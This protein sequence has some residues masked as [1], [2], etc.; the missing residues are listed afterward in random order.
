MTVLVEDL[1]WWSV[2][3]QSTVGAVRR[4]ATALGTELGLSDGRVADLGIVAAE[5]TSNLLKHANDGAVHLRALR[6][7]AGRPAG[8]ELVAIDAGPGMA[9]LVASS[10]DGHS[11]AGTLGIGLGAISRQATRLDVFSEPGR[12]TV[13]V[14]AVWGGRPPPEPWA[15]GLTRPIAGE[16]VSGDAYSVREVSGRRQ[17]FLS[18]G[19]GHGPLASRASQTAA[20]AFRDA[21]AGSPAAVLEHLHRA[22]AHTRGAVGAVIELDR[23]AGVLSCASVGNIAGWVVG[24]QRRR[25]L[26]AQPGFLGDRQRRTIREYTTALNDEDVV[27]LHTDGLTDRWN[28]ADYPGLLTREPLTI[29]ATLLRDAGLRRDDAGVLVAR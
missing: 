11:T 20:T 21:P 3:E 2:S 27:V 16:T 18:D 24:H 12:G 14:A 6:D 22:V 1:G 28:L 23:A 19:L 5:V 10:R 8:V 15:V 17:A 29:A 13:L 9:D 7:D 25:G 4:A 26:A